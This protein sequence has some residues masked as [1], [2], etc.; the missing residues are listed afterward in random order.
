[1]AGFWRQ[2]VFILLVELRLVAY[3]PHHFLLA[4]VGFAV[5]TF[6]LVSLLAVT[7]GLEKAGANSGSAAV[8]IVMSKNTGDETGSSL[9]KEATGI[10]AG[11]PGVAE[12][13]GHPAVAP[14][15]L[16]TVKI[17][18]RGSELE[19]SVLVRGVTARAFAMTPGFHII[20]G[21]RFRAGT[22]ELISGAA[23]AQSFQWMT[24]GSLQQLANARWDMVGVF[25]A[26]GGYRSSEIWTDLH[27][28]Q[29]ALN[30]SGRLSIVVAKL[31]SPDAFFRFKQ[32][33]EQDKRLEA[34]AVRQS[35]Y[36][37]EKSRFLNHFARLAIWGIAILLG[38]GAIIGTLNIVSTSLLAR[39][40]EVALY[41]AIGFRR[42]AVVVALLIDVVLVGLVAGVI[43]GICAM[44]IFNGYQAVTSTGTRQLAFT[45][46]ATPATVAAG[47][48][49]ASA[50]GMLSGIVPSWQASRRSICQSLRAT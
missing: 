48:V 44:L 37:A 8:A 3:R 6:V 39:I 13:D 29:S 47:I 19:G 18:R 15:L 36:F 24:P 26:K 21:R 38:A 17:P 31:K 10:V 30:A 45:L 11:L 12:F 2:F 1:M 40:R 33:V 35:D 16:T 43:G 4:F 27:T 49:Y 14:E 20:D 32:S 25:A 9:T 50:L 34:R 5:V 42:D 41:R 28:L 22:N 7:A 23:A 46:S